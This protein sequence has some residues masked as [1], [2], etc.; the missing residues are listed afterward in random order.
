M[1]FGGNAK[2]QSTKGHGAPVATSVISSSQNSLKNNSKKV[3]Q[4]GQ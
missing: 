4:V 2:L 1:Q 3:R